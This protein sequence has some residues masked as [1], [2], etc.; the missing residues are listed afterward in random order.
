MGG[1][2]EKKKASKEEITHG[3]QH[4]KLVDWNKLSIKRRRK[5]GSAAFIFQY[6]RGEKRFI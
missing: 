2:I 4:E 1:K 5:A 6:I 3:E